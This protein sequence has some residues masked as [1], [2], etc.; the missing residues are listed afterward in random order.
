ML[1]SSAMFRKSGRVSVWIGNLKTE[2]ELDEYLN[3]T[4]S[5]ENDFGFEL[6]ERDIREFTVEPYAKEI[7][8][9]VNGFSA[10]ESFAQN[11]V[12]ASQVA[13][14]N[15]ASTMLIFYAFEFDPSKVN[16]NTAAPLKF[17]GSFPF[18]E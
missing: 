8:P 11:V 2:H 10:C 13:G 14:I 6:D 5:F 15:K 1:K 4:H 9:L 16:V 17:I 12:Q 7:S 3:L 18:A